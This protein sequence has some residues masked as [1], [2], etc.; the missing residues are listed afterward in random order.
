MSPVS[1][2]HAPFTRTP[3]EQALDHL[4]VARAHVGLFVQQIPGDHLEPLRSK[5]LAVVGLL[6]RTADAVEA[7]EIDVYPDPVRRPGWAAPS[8]ALPVVGRREIGEHTR[9]G[10][11]RLDSNRGR[12]ARDSR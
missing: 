12:H 8:E 10:L 9:E 5:L 1:E 6:D 7:G 11:R 3:T 2:K 4:Q